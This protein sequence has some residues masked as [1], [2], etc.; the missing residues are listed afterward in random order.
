MVTEST[1][2]GLIVSTSPRAAAALDEL[3]VC[4]GWPVLLQATPQRFRRELLLGV[5]KLSLFWLDDE[6][7]VAT[8]VQLLSWLGT[9]Q[10]AVRRVA[11]GYQLPANVEVAVRSAGAHM[12][13]AAA[14]NIR[15][16]LD[17]SIAPWLRGRDRSAVEFSERP[18][19]VDSP[20]GSRASP[21]GVTLHPSG[22]P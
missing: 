21:L 22:P 13:L 14:D 3:I 9:Y 11:V 18:F 17:G 19:A 4:C 10:P 6:R 7:D 20:R 1:S 15:A 5:P 16:L 2:Q 12:Y 8:T